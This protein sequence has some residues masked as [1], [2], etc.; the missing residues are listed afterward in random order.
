MLRRRPPPGLLVKL[1]A[2]ALV[3]ATKAPGPAAKLPVDREADLAG[4]HV[5]RVD[6]VVVAVDARA[7]E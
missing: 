2:T 5:E 1:C 7:L 4:E 6:M 3:A